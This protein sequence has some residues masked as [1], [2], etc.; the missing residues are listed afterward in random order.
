MVQ[1]KIDEMK[2]KNQ[3]EFSKGTSHLRAAFDNI[4]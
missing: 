1:Q 3:G 2:M 4:N